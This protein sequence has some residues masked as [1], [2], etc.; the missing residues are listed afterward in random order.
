MLK[1]MTISNALLASRCN[2]KTRANQLIS[3]CLPYIKCT[4]CP[5]YAFE[6]AAL[7]AGIYL[8]LVATGGGKYSVDALIDSE[9]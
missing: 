5:Q 6:A 7:Y 2:F 1:F 3:G 9:E 4:I 8:C